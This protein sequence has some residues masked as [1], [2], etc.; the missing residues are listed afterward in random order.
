[1]RNF[2]RKAGQL[3]VLQYIW[4]KQ[5]PVE[6]WEVEQHF[7]Y[8]SSGARVTLHRLRRKGLVVAMRPGFYEPTDA[9]IRRLR[10]H[11][12]IR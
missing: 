5:R 11:K 9:G 10:Y 2:K 7:N 12:L 6:A 3:V 1:M 4:E 8:G